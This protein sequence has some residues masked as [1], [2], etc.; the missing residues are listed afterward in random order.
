MRKKGV[1]QIVSVLLLVLIAVLLLFLVF[2][3]F[4]DISEMFKSSAEKQ[5]DIEKHKLGEKFRVDGFDGQNLKIKNTGTIEL[6]DLEV[7]IENNPVSYAP[8]QP[9]QPGQIATLVLNKDEIPVEENLTVSV[10]SAYF[11]TQVIIDTSTNTIISED[12]IVL[13]NEVEAS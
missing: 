2:G 9:I 4:N 13:I 3:F 1:T 10:K 8:I 6:S 7:Y 12:W 11:M 5:S